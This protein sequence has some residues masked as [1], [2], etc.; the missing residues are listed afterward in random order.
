MVIERKAW[1]RYFPEQPQA[2]VR[3]FFVCLSQKRID[4]L[5]ESLREQAV[6]D[7]LRFATLAD[8]T[9]RQPASDAI[10]QD[11]AGNRREI[12]RR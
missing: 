6:K 3:V 4:A 7:F 2:H 1:L 12:V 10:W 8:M 5:R 11:I 9:T